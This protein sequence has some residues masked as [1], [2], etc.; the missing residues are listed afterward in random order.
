MLSATLIAVALILGYLVAVGLSMMVFFGVARTAPQFVVKGHLV[1][2][3]YKLLEE[4]VWLVC[5][6]AGSYLSALV[7]E[8]TMRPMLVGGLLALILIL[9]LWANRWETRQRGLG[10]QLLM[11][12][13][14]A[15]GV[16]AGYY[17]ALS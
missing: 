1:R 14:S 6:T 12:A 9:V 10:H 16:A 2:T 13:V 11:S 7:A 4:L 8:L 15:A 3:R 5:V 17:L